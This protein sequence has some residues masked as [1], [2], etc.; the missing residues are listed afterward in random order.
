MNITLRSTKG[1][2]ILSLNR[3]GISIPD[4]I[5][6]CAYKGQQLDELLLE[7][8][9]FKDINLQSLIARNSKFIKCTFDGVS[10][11]N[12]DLTGT[13]FDNCK[14]DH[15]DVLNCSLRGASYPNTVIGRANPKISI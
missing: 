6:Q 9:N 13:T 5:Q 11:R 12:G 10:F 8:I 4:I 14:I 7:N 2:P 1:E 3:S 15:V